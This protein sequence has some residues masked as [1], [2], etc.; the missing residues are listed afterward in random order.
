L[1]GASLRFFKE[2]MMPSQVTVRSGDTLW[3]IARDNNTT[4]DAL[5]R[6]NNITDPNSIRVGA[7]L[8]LPGASDS[9]ER[10]P[11]AAVNA[12][13]TAR[14]VIGGA[15]VVAAAKARAEM[16]GN[17]YGVPSKLFSPNP[18]LAFNNNPDRSGVG[19]TVNQ[20][21]CNQFGGDVLYQAGFEPPMY[22][23]PGYYVIAEEWPN[24]ARGPNRCFDLITDMS[25]ARPG[26][27]VIADHPG[28]GAATGH[29]RVLTSE[30]ADDGSFS[31]IS[32]HY[33][34]AYESA[35][36]FLSLKSQEEAMYILRPVR[37]RNDD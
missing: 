8:V 24:Y 3:R 6:A 23:K 19:G 26:D 17:H 7:T 31:S 12:T 2:E 21:K 13:H 32:A 28:E 5:V 36:N 37:V 25:Q 22:S 27:I 1:P 34:A 30:I 15:Q 16:F 20:W 11:A 29:V 14:P 18:N 4:V 35:E 10:A 9:F 33:D